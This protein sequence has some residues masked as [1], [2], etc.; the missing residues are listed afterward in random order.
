MSTTEPFQDSVKRAWM[1]RIVPQLRPPSSAPPAPAY[2]VPA[3]PVPNDTEWLAALTRG[4][5]AALAR[6]Y[7]EHHEPVRALVRRLLS[8]SSEIEDVVHD[9]FV[10]APAA[11][12]GYRGEG[13]VRSFVF[14]IAVHHVGH[15]V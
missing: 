15:H 5:E 7:R 9:I 12:R 8:R 11:F 6:L 14:S 4:E 1:P 2:A 3:L 13:T 10:A